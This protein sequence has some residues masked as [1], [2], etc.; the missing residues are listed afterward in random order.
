MRALSLTWI[1]LFFITLM[2]GCSRDS[3]MKAFTSPEDEKTAKN[4]ISLLQQQKL[5]QLENDLDPAIKAKSSNVHQTL[6]DMASRIPAQTPL[7]IKLVSASFLT[8]NKQHK[9]D[10]TYEYQYPDRS[11][12]VRIAVKKEDGVSTITGFNVRQLS[13]SLES[14]NR[15]SLSGK[16]TLQYAVLAAAVIAPLFSLYALILCIRTKM[17]GKK[18][19]W[20]IAILLGVGTLAVNW[21]TGHWAFQ[22]LSVQLFS[23]SAWAPQYGTWTIS[24]SLPLGAILFMLRRKELGISDEQTLAPN[25]AME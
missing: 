23:A 8:S 19:L 15:F 20:I 10:I 11:I 16:N 1:G 14:S 17:R 18:W 7:S 3:L 24:V 21:T 22:P 2:A 9:S 12:L 5:D 13:D 25:P 4:Y 6:L